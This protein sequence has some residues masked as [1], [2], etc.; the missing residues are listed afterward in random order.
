M[1]SFDDTTSFDDITRE[2]IKQHNPN[3]SQ[4]SDHPYRIL[5]IGDTGSGKT[6]ALLTLIKQQDNDDY[7]ITDKM[8]Y[9]SI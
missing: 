6:N 9:R 5:I 2:N 8:C 4:I 1:I 7:S 3:W